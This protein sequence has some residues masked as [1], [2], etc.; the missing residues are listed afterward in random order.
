MDKDLVLAVMCG[1]SAAA[2]Y[3]LWAV[4]TNRQTRRD[5][6]FASWL[7]LFGGYMAYALLFV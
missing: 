1:F 5:A 2:A 4:L 6:F 3:F 7:V